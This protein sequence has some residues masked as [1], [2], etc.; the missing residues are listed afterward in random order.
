MKNEKKNSISANGLLTYLLHYLP[1]T[2]A[3]Y[4]VK[5]LVRQ[6]YRYHAKKRELDFFCNAERISYSEG[7]F[8]YVF[9]QRSDP[10]VV[11]VHGWGGASYQWHQFIPFLIESGYQVFV[12]DITAHGNSDG[13]SIEFS[14]FWKDLEKLDK[15]IKSQVYCY[16]GHSAGGLGVMVAKNLNLVS[17][18]KFCCISAPSRPYPPLKILTKKFNITDSLLLAYKN[19]L[20]HEFGAKSWEDLAS[21]CY[22]TNDLSDLL[23][24]YDDQDRYLDKND[25]LNI[26]DVVSHYK[27]KIF[28]GAGHEGILY[29]Q[30]TIDEVLSFLSS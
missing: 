17:A 14:N 26:C 29:K 1:T 2:M 23:L 10:I 18:K 5:K 20:C 7:L 9:G 3:L 24:I 6:P 21:F 22:K 13:S 25:Y 8:A 27:L 28:S 12:P 4:L 16:I 15:K 30:E 19:S 11:L